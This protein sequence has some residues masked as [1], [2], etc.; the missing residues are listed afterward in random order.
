MAQGLTALPHIDKVLVVDDVVT[1]RRFAE[2]LLSGAGYAVKSAVAG[3][4]ALVTFQDW[5]PDL[6]LLDICMPGL[7]GFETCERIRAL[8][9]GANVPI[10]FLT[11][12]GD[13]T[14]YQRALES[15][16][17]D[18]LPK[19]LKRSELLIRVRSLLRIARL[20]RELEEGSKLIR[21]Q[22]DAIRSHR[23]A[24]A[25]AQEQKVNLISWMVHDLKSPLASILSNSEFLLAS[26][27]SSPSPVNGETRAALVDIHRGAE[28]IHRKV[29]NLLD[30]NRS[31]ESG[32][33]PS[34]AAT[35]LWDLVQDTV[36]LFKRRLAEREMQ[37]ELRRNG[38]PEMCTVDREL[39][40]RVVENLV[41]NC[42]KYAPRGS[43]VHVA[44]QRADGCIDLCVADQGPGIPAERRAHLFEKYAHY[45]PAGNGPTRGSHGLGLAFCRRVAEAHG[46]EISFEPL[47]PRGSLFRL[48]L[49]AF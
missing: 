13:M 27:S 15:G 44:I 30:I 8:P 14:A 29:V 18:F 4:E 40:G 47:E 12:M 33:E 25:A 9:G 19:P 48:R 38:G 11:S 35:D 31:E 36:E 17:D 21:R 1:I 22:H 37:L 49:P 7:D 5:A 6:V 43:Q 45:S 20:T 16:A 46:G 34:L 28:A 26:S 24:L 39:I 32:L 42:L 23:D 41:D 3:E 10:L 2:M